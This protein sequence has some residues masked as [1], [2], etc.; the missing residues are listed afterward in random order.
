MFEPLIL[1]DARGRTIRIESPPERIV[2]LVPSLTQLLA[3]LELEERVAGI[4]RFCTQPAGWK[5]NKV[6]V[7]GTK[8]VNLERVQKLKPDLILANIEENVRP[9]VE[10]LDELAPV[11]VTDISRLE[12]ALTAIETIGQLTGQTSAAGTLVEEISARFATIPAVPPLRALY[13]IWRQPYMTV[14]RDTFIHDM[15]R[16]GSFINVFARRTRYPVVSPEEITAANPDVVLL[17][18]EPY[19]FKQEHADEIRAF[20]PT[21]PIFFVEGA[22]FSWYGSGLLDTPSYIIYLHRVMNG[23]MSG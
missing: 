3:D 19:P 7:G 13:L 9:D 16:Y 10:Q 6:I 20:L 15:M 11:Y 2:S 14:G 22:A 21:T 4:T 18:S 8:N 12:D 17:S 1:T 5:S 23:A